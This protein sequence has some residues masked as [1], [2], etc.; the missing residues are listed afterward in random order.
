MYSVRRQFLTWLWM[1]LISYNWIKITKYFFSH[2]SIFQQLVVFLK[3]KIFR[4]SSG[5]N[6][7]FQWWCVSF[8]TVPK[9]WKWCS[10]QRG[11]KMC[12]KLIEALQKR[13]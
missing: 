1:I 10:I 13:P 2:E 7:N 3:E 8:P 9:E 12:T 4:H 6:K 11:T 5:P